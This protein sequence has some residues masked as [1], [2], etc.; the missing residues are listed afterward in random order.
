MLVKF[1]GREATLHRMI[2]EK[3]GSVRAPNESVQRSLDIERVLG[4]ALADAELPSPNAEEPPPKVE[5]KVGPNVEPTVEPTMEELAKERVE[6]DVLDDLTARLIGEKSAH[7]SDV[8]DSTGKDQTK[9]QDCNGPSNGSMGRKF[10]RLLPRS[11]PQDHGGEPNGGAARKQPQTPRLLPRSPTGRAGSEERKKAAPVP[12][13]PMPHPGAGVAGAAA[14]A[15]PQAKRA[16]T[17]RFADE[18]MVGAEV[19]A[20]PAALTRAK[21]RPRNA[22]PT[23]EELA[24]ESVE[25]DMLDVLTSRLAGGTSMHKSDAVQSTGKDP[26]SASRPAAREPPPQ[27]V[28][29]DDDDFRSI[30]GS[31]AGD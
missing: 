19:A 9:L 17:E 13:R 11:P 7:K 18:R 26:P 3:Y 23:M 5:P 14:A 12:A 21:G 20:A 10:P 25:R 28:E 29:E 22:E 30:F 24:K 4:E 2:C 31:D 16:R 27:V 8:V 1:Q 15:A 6:G